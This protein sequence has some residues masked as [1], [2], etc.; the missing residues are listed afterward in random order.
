MP[1]EGVCLKDHEEMLTEDEF[2]QA[3]EVAAGLGMRKIRLTG[4]EPL[5]RKNVVGICARI[6]K[7]PG[8]EEVCFTTNGL[9]LPKLG[10]DLVAAGATGV[11][12]SLDTLR[13]EKFEY[14][15]R[16]PAPDDLLCGLKAA[17]GAGFKKVKINAVLI[18]GVNDDEIE[19]EVKIFQNALDF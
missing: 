3:A 1:E 13:K 9:L 5:V 7:I 6:S 2:V 15:S 10:K 17:L 16:R 14:I 12:L 8:I 19:E 11:N 4:G 18:G